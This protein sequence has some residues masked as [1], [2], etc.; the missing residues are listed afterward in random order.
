MLFL[1]RFRILNGLVLAAFLVF[2]GSAVAQEGFTPS[3]LVFT[4]FADGVVRVDYDLDAD[5]TKPRILVP[6][7]GSIYENLI[8]LDGDRNP[9]DHAQ[10]GQIIS[11]DSLG[12]DSVNISY[13]TLDLTNKTGR[14]WTVALETP[15]DALVS[16]PER[17]TIISVN[18]PPQ[19]FSTI[20]ERPVLSMPGGI[21]IISYS[22][23]VLGT[24]EHALALILDAE[25]GIA[26]IVSQ[27]V[28]VTE[29]EDQLREARL[30]LD[31]ERF[32][33]AEELATNAISLASGI[34]KDAGEAQSS[35]DAARTAINSALQEG[36]TINLEEAQRLISEA[37]GKYSLGEYEDA[38]AQADRGSEIARLASTPGSGQTQTPTPP[39]PTD[40]PLPS[41]DGDTGTLLAIVGI[42][43]AVAIIGVFLVRRARRETALQSTPAEVSQKQ[44]RD[45]DLA[46]ILGEKPQL[47]LEDQDVI[48]FI[49]DSG[50]EA[51]EGEIREKFRLPKTTVWRMVKRLVSEEIIEV[52][53][54]R[55]NNLVRIL[56]NYE[57]QT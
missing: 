52:K 33:A 38:K 41:I 12:S 9:L 51:Y 8:V 5:I 56:P 30:A 1:I 23:G 7:F 16:L 2:S 53:N 11:I 32:S 46:K 17:T 27:G 45:I 22:I 10:F 19:A 24:R 57:K 36:R 18:Q 40:G 34:E 26:E 54:I 28:N 37:E 43:A 15:K 31:Q 13:E 35:I 29:A 49:A 50:G 3:T 6:L 48:R 44:W 21:V 39:P 42:I 55:G 47:R 14:V 4:V 25:D 20:R